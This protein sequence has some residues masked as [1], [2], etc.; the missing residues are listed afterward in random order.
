MIKLF[1]NYCLSLMVVFLLL[2]NHSLADEV[3]KIEIL[4]NERIPIETIK[5]FSK[6]SINVHLLIIYYMGCGYM[7]KYQWSMVQDHHLKNR[8]MQIS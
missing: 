7:G 8:S 1:L 3:L 2:I 6:V 5:T 4:G